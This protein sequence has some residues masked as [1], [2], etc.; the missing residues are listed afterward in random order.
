ME[1]ENTNISEISDDEKSTENVD[2]IT[3]DKKTSENTDKE[4]CSHASTH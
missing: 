2:I 3:E 4:T 1:E